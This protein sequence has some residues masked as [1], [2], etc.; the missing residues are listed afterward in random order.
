MPWHVA[1]LTGGA[2]VDKVIGGHTLDQASAYSFEIGFNGA[3]RDPLQHALPLVYTEPDAGALGAAQHLR[4]GGPDGELPYAPRRREAADHP[5]SVPPTRPCGRCGWR[6]STLAATGDLAAFDA[7]L[8]V[9][10]R[11]T[12]PH[13]CRCASI[14]STSSAT[15]S[16]ASAAASTATC[17]S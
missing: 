13:P 6:P 7:P 12:Q 15:S 3:A 1:L 2:C 5:S 16:I 17:A 14:S 11:S 10:T 4:V 9:S 8:A